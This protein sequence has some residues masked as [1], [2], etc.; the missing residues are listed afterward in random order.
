MVMFSCDEAA[1]ALARRYRPSGELGCGMAKLQFNIPA[2]VTLF[3]LLCPI[4]G[5]GR[6][7]TARV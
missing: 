6:T 5:R 2:R 7:A 1:A 3:L 4:S